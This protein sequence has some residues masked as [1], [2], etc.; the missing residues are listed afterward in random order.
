MPELKNT[1]T[2]G[3]MNKDLDERLIPN[4]QY[5][6]A[7]NV[8]VST[9]EGSDVGTVQN[10][11]GNLQVDQGIVGS[12][13]KCIGSIANEKT[14]KIYW[15]VTSSNVDAI[16]EYEKD[17]LAEAVFVDTKVGTA[18]AVLKFTNKIITGI[19]IIDDMLFWTDNLNEPRKI[20]IERCKK[21]TQSI[22]THTKLI[23]ND[24]VATN[25]FLTIA[26][27]DFTGATQIDLNNTQVLST[28]M[29][30]VSINGVAQDGV[31]IDSVDTAVQ[32]TLNLPVNVLEDDEVIF[33]L[34]V[35]I[36]EDHIVVIKKRPKKAPKFKLNFD[37][38]IPKPGLFE[39]KFIRFA[40][41]YKYED[42]EYS[43]FG[44]FTD[45]VF[46]PKYTDDY[47]V[48]TAFSTKEPY[49][50]A[51]L[52][53]I[54]SVELSNFI[55]P[56]T[57]KDVTQIDI[58][59]SQE[60]SPVVY[61]VASIKNTEE[62]FNAD[63]YSQGTNLATGYKGKYTITS[64]NIYAAIPENQLLRSWDN[65]PKKALSQEV[66]GNRVVYGNYTQNYSLGLDG[67]DEPIKP[68][69]NVDFDLRKNIDDF[70]DG[71]LPSIKSQRNYQLGVVFGD[72]YGRETPVFT[73]T[74]GAI[75]VPWAGSLGK[76]ASLSTQLTANLTS[77]APS[78]ASYYKFYIKE[79]S[80]EYY[81]LVMDKAYVPTHEVDEEYEDPYLWLSFNSSDRNKLKEED[82]VILKKKIGT[83][84]N[85]IGIENRLKV[86]DISNEAPDA[87]RYRFNGV[88][89][90][91]NVDDILSNLS[92]LPSGQTTSSYDVGIMFD[93]DFRIDRET[94]EIHIHKTNLESP[95]TSG[96]NLFTNDDTASSGDNLYISWQDPSTG[97]AS[98]RYRVVSGR[99]SNG[100]VYMLKLS[101]DISETD[102]LIASSN[103]GQVAGTV[104]ALT[105]GLILK[106]ERK[107]LKDLDEFSGRFF[108]KV[109]LDETT[110]NVSQYSLISQIA[111]DYVISAHAKMFWLHDTLNTTDN[112]PS[113]GLV[114]GYAFPTADT[115][116]SEYLTSLNGSI[117]GSPGGSAVTDNLG[118]WE[119]LEVGPVQNEFFIDNMGF[120]AGQMDPVNSYAKTAVDPVHGVGWVYTKQ[121]WT[122]LKSDGSVSPGGYR[123]F[124]QDMDEESYTESGGVFTYVPVPNPNPS[125]INTFMGPGGDDYD[126][127]DNFV[128][129]MEGIMQSGSYPEHLKQQFGNTIFGI[130]EPRR[131]W[132]QPG[133]Y[134]DNVIPAFT[135]NTYGE[136][137]G[138]AGRH[139]IHLSFLA[140][141]KNLHNNA[142]WDSS[143]DLS[144]YQRK[145]KNGLGKNLQGIW[146][147]GVFVKEDGGRFYT[148]N[149][150]PAKA[151][152]VVEME[153]N[154]TSFPAGTASFTSS[155]QGVFIF[156]QTIYPTPG[157]NS[158]FF[159]P[160][161]TSS[162]NQTIGYA[163][164]DAPGPGTGIGYDTVHQEL[165]ENQWNPTYGRDSFTTN[166]INTF[167]AN[168]VQGAKFTFSDDGDD[169]VYTILNSPKQSAKRLYNHTPWR[170]RYVWNGT[171]Y[172]FGNDS[173]EEKAIAWAASQTNAWTGGDAQIGTDL[174]AF[175]KRFGFANNRRICYIIEVDKDPTSATSN[176]NPIG[177]GG[178]Q[179]DANTSTK[180]QFLQE[181]PR[182]LTGKVSKQPAIWETEPKET[183]DLDIYYETNSLIPTKINEKTREVFAPIGC[184]VEFPGSPVALN[185]FFN[186]SQDVV[187][188]EWYTNN[189]GNMVVKLNPGL[190]YANINGTEINYS[191]AIF[192]FIREDGSFT[193]G[194][195]SP[196][197]FTPAGQTL[198]STDFRT[199]FVLTKVVDTSLDVGLSWY[200][201][202]SFGNGIESN[203]IRDDFNE[204]RI[205][206]GP[207]A[208]TTTE[209][210]YEEEHRK[211]GL[212]YSGLYNSNSGINNLNQFIQADK[213]TKDLNPTFG[214]IQKLF[215]RRASLIAFCEDRVINILSNRDALFNAD[216][217]PQLISS[218]AVLGDATPFVGDYGIS[219]NPE[220]FSKESYRAYFSDKQRGAILRL[221]K[222]GLT[223]ISDQGMHDWFRDNLPDAGQMIGSY[224]EYKKD[225]N[226][227]L[228]N[229]ILQN[230]FT[231]AD[232]GEGLDI[233]ETIPSVEIISNGGINQGLELQMP[234]VDP[235]SM[236]ILNGEIES[237]TTITNHPAIPINTLL[238]ETPVAATVTYSPS[239]FTHGSGFNIFNNSLTD[240]SE[241]GDAFTPHNFNTNIS[242]G[243]NTNNKT[244]LTRKG[245]VGVI[246]LFGTGIQE[247]AEVPASG[248][249]NYTNQLI[250]LGLFSAGPLSTAFANSGVFHD[251][252]MGAANNYVGKPNIPII[253]HDNTNSNSSATVAGNASGLQ[254]IVFRTYG[255]KANHL[256]ITGQGNFYNSPGYTYAN[257]MQAYIAFRGYGSSNPINGGYNTIKRYDS[258]SSNVSN[259]NPTNPNA[260]PVDASGNYDP[261]GAIPNYSSVHNL[262]I[263]NGE[264]LR[265]SFKGRAAV[266]DAV[267][268]YAHDE[269]GN[270]VTG[271]NSGSGGDISELDS[272]H[273]N[274]GN[275]RAGFHVKLIDRTGSVVAAGNM[276]SNIYIHV[277][278]NGDYDAS[279]LP[280][281]SIS[282]S[283]GNSNLQ[284]STTLTVGTDS[285]DY[286][287]QKGFVQNSYVTFPYLPR[288][289]SINT[290]YFEH[291]VHFK[292]TDPS[293]PN[294]E[295]ILIEDLEVRI[296]FKTGWLN[297]LHEIWLKDLSITKA[298]ALE[299]PQSITITPGST[300]PGVPTEDVPAWAEVQHNTP[301]WSTT[302]N[303]PD[304]SLHQ[305]AIDT[306]GPA[307]GQGTNETE[308]SVTYL[309]PPGFDVANPS[310]Y[311]ANNSLTFYNDGTGATGMYGISPDI[312]SITGLASNSSLTMADITA[313]NTTTTLVNNTGLKDAI[314]ISTT[315]TEYITQPL[316]VSFVPDN[317]YMVD[318]ITDGNFSGT[319]NVMA[320][321]G[322]LD[323]NIQ[324]QL[325]V[326]DTNYPENHYG[327]TK[328]SAGGA[329]SI[330]LLPATNTNYGNGLIGSGEDVYR[331]IFK[332]HSNSMINQQNELGTFKLL[333][334]HFTGS[335]EE[336]RIIDI[337]PPSTGG[338][339]T[340]WELLNMDNL[341][342]IHSLTEPVVYYKNNAINFNTTDGY[343]KTFKQ[344]FIYGSSPVAS[345]DGFKF[346][347]TIEKAVDAFG[348]LLP[349]SG[350][351]KSFI[352]TDFDNSL[353]TPA[354]EGI[355]LDNFSNEG[356]YEIDFNFDGNSSSWVKKLDG[357]LTTH[358]SISDV[359]NISSHNN[360]TVSSFSNQIRFYPDTTTGFT[361]A[362]SGV[363]LVDKTNFFS[364]GTV[365]SWSF[366]GFNANL[367]NFIQFNTQGQNILFINAPQTSIGTVQ[368]QQ[369]IPNVISEDEYFRIKFD[370][371]L[372]S[373]DING[374]Y[375]NHEGKGF[376]LGSISS[377]GSYDALHRIGDVVVTASDPELRNTFVIFVET[378]LVTGTLDN[379][380]MQQ[381]FP[382]YEEKT[383]TYNESVKG[384]V[385]FKSFIPEQGVSVAK[386]YY[387][388]KQGALWQ[389]HINEIRNTFYDLLTESSVTAL[390]N[391]SP[392]VVKTF[393]TLNYEGSKSKINKYID[394]KAGSTLDTYNS[395]EKQGW[396]VDSIKTDKQEG[397][398]KEFIEK[399]GKW[400]NYIRGNVN[401]IKTSDFSFQGLGIISDVSTGGLS[402][403]TSGGGGG[404][405]SSS[406]T[407]Y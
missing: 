135:D 125:Q 362:I 10:I 300:L 14:N 382:F 106:I 390:L 366:S 361:G 182:V 97:Q 16:L 175:I 141:G 355:F 351:L 386:R 263:F 5:R 374:Y 26:D 293:A 139:F 352:T 369:T 342:Q 93:E 48:D 149:S 184:K 269:D 177:G 254:G 309:V 274:H 346:K 115:T 78:W 250:N 378:G 197:M 72:K 158:G 46:S 276:V 181:D 116:V 185:G 336:I 24:V 189:A 368:V 393:N 180:I 123:W 124:P 270:D 230:L 156:G 229:P 47:N 331:A 260:L 34:P 187:L 172:V 329:R 42:G 215:Q 321:Y 405:S 216:G 389:H 170:R 54:A 253:A 29:K 207:R 99:V 211:Y 359:T 110:D 130:K 297:E 71:G 403:S 385:S 28:G 88:Q 257:S 318:V 212:I 102:T 273:A 259:W 225:Y 129:G 126:T 60:N 347:F 296:Y 402:I 349:I 147:G 154:Y 169:T 153:G 192:K 354:Y 52:N 249:G 365:Y 176:Y 104:G 2:Q 222:D 288:H 194:K 317:W 186:I 251:R 396:Y 219:K 339:P 148:T 324:T 122:N 243:P 128:N 165:H 266:P 400:F 65:V 63:G 261:N 357:I 59:Y 240:S 327:T 235:N 310:N 44:P 193:T 137:D 224:D 205:L 43:A 6:D 304:T 337:T 392:S 140:P 132:R 32:I 61:S 332:V 145:G 281:D 384:W 89:L 232:V 231:N 395:K 303:D 307:T 206:N 326:G 114:N 350:D 178:T 37:P 174:K 221:S 55:S 155:A 108:V 101:N 9:S 136:V 33:S 394:H 159:N 150:T 4:G 105:D 75:K 280:Y 168:L 199:D 90:I 363:S 62:D 330:E 305:R 190:N 376:R 333:F 109:I 252:V 3:K 164:E 163:R 312:T 314:Y 66:T 85:Q 166:K 45:V 57:P 335:I 299:T 162:K 86:I 64:E 301:D 198:T 82:Y 117:A 151:E 358:G 323:S 306:Y 13:F 142:G 95:P 201:C 246:N 79:T 81:N 196:T 313:L 241:A 334:Y 247:I 103:P 388:V 391:E 356:A 375:F 138:T 308:S 275:G 295:K 264:E 272:Y 245:S 20:N 399:E 370:Y 91:A 256:E 8:Q 258:V 320:V 112:N 134:I 209:E 236:N 322:V 380:V 404:S 379:L 118:Q 262:T 51:M 239:V 316:T 113:N 15:F 278:N 377:A 84:E 144:G 94:D 319:N 120:V 397:T 226:L 265:I 53:H 238:P 111:N 80:G 344:E 255:S 328:G 22:N 311:T 345:T 127:G 146:G 18:D 340:N 244:F 202:F 387:T 407:S 210:P 171:D 218:N 353:A 292:F 277:P 21:G 191:N 267:G 119:V 360:G 291:R 248:S 121:V 371:N 87:I 325:N 203:R 283:A 220:S 213:I 38:N 30:L 49:N 302:N 23:V 56:D 290:D 373:G 234:T 31:F 286:E 167:L 74:E 183:A 282:Y 67:H 50:A 36:T 223:P 315:G 233:V 58:L 157:A 338:I 204:M 271:S 364:G 242:A 179:P 92:N 298:Y 19:N 401:D 131:G 11:L 133:P 77:E 200:N 161:Y 227:T 406:T 398:I 152:R 287:F 228:T 348:T 217:N 73:S 100:N 1:F 284:G 341:N 381:E 7:M 12:D 195:V 41:R 25:K 383:I 372:T 107:E 294:T 289:S 160:A 173:V 279:L 208:S 39:K 143:T 70:Q 268:A 285:H 40:C 17:K 98:T 188:E 83:G 237:E 367:F 214:S 76:N 27:D 96:L 35:E 343:G 69:L 68:G